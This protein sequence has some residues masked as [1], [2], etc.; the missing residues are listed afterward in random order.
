M[1]NPW[2]RMYSEFSHDPKVQMLP[3]VMQRRLVMLLCL[4]CSDTL[5]TLRDDDIAFHL[6][7][8]PDDLAE[9]KA[10]FLANGFIKKDWEIANWAKRQFVSDKSAERQKAYRDRQRAR[11]KLTAVT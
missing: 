7:I 1:A 10:L 3:E 11:P 8:T 6:R 2:F 9:T 4:R 5:K